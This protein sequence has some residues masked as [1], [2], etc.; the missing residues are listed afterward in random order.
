MIKIFSQIGEFRPSLQLVS[1]PA[2]SPQQLF[3]LATV[4]LLKSQDRVQSCVSDHKFISLA[5]REVHPTPTVIRQRILPE[6]A[7]SELLTYSTLGCCCCWSCRRRRRRVLALHAASALS[8][9]EKR[10]DC[11]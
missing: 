1:A 2:T 5:E 7:M 6:A 8:G 3:A 4:S 10:G 11:I 9:L